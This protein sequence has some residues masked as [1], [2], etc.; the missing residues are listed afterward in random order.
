MPLWSRKPRLVRVRILPEH[1]A[2]AVQG[3]LLPV[4]DGVVVGIQPVVLEVVAYVLICV[5]GGPAVIL[6]G[7]AVEYHIVDGAYGV[8]CGGRGLPAHVTAVAYAG[9][10]LVGT[11]GGDEDDTV[12]CT[13]AV[14]CRGGCVLEHGDLVYLRGIH[15]VDAAL[16]AVDEHQRGRTAAA[17]G[18]D[19]ADADVA[20]IGART[21]AVGGDGDSGNATLKRSRCLR[22][23]LVVKHFGGDGAHGSSQVDLFLGAVADHHDVV[24]EFGVGL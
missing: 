21:A 10:A 6:S 19:T 11:F 18:A 3:V 16:D 4:D 24:Q 12:G 17:E 23:W 7:L 5:D 13:G 8:G 2:A 14:D 9:L 15:R 1:Q 20:R 22:N